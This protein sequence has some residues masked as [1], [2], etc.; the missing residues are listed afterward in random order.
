MS[1][2]DALNGG[3]ATKKEK[4]TK[5]EA[6]E[7]KVKVEQE[8]VEE[9][10]A[11]ETAVEET[12]TEETVVEEAKSEETKSETIVEENGKEATAITENVTEEK[13]EGAEETA[14][15]ETVTEEKIQEV[16]E[17]STEEDIKD[18]G[19]V[20]NDNPDEDVEIDNT[21]RLGPDG[22]VLTGVVPGSLTEVI[23]GGDGSSDKGDKNETEET[24]EETTEIKSSDVD[25]KSII[26]SRV[27]THA[28]PQTPLEEL[29]SRKPG[30]KSVKEE[31]VSRK[32]NLPG[33]RYQAGGRRGRK[34]Q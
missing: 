19:E 21:P 9:I 32:R 7:D 1:V 29:N 22:E 8:S 12:A 6:V 10:V 31:L 5:K 24:V 33:Q 30:Y 23:L 34:I 17:T 4:A 3:S 27:I 11:E 13:A 14:V 25:I 20:V 28:R 18:G 2:K 26:A 15:E 16:G